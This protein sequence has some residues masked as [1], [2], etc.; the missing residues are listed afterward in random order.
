MRIASLLDVMLTVIS[1]VIYKPLDDHTN[2]KNKNNKIIG[3]K[4]T[5][6]NRN[7]LT[8]KVFLMIMIN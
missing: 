5:F 2:N 8:I 3:V 6:K 1:K 7:F 4:L